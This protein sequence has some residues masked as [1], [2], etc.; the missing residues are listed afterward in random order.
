[1]TG[2]GDRARAGGGLFW[3]SGVYISVL[4][5]GLCRSVAVGVERVR[6]YVGA[7][8]RVRAL[9]WRRVS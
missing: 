3:G 5:M 1:M 9:N 6:V 4:G 2:P 8:G 7:G